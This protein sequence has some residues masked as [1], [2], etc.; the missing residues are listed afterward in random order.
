M[1]YFLTLSIKLRDF[2]KSGKR[3][4]F[5]LLLYELVCFQNWFCDF[6]V[7][8]IDC[9]LAKYYFQKNQIRAFFYKQ[10]FFSTLPQCCLTFSWIGLQMLHRCSLTHIATIILRHILYLVY[11]CLYLGQLRSIYVV[12]MWSTFHFQLHFH[13]H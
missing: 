11:L 12:S 3:H 7:P 4:Y 8:R 6:I 1:I 13:C 2:E 10:L 5:V 9:F